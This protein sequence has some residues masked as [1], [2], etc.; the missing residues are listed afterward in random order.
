MG[1]DAL[2]I[3]PIHTDADLQQAKRRLLKLIRDNK[4]GKHDDEIEVLSTLAE[5]FENSQSRVGSPTP[6]AAI[7]FRMEEL[8][9]TARQLEPFIGS[10]ARVSEVLSGKRQLSIDMIRALHEGLGIPYESL[11]TQRLRTNGGNQVSAPTLN[12]LNTLGFNV[13]PQGVPSFITSILKNDAPLA[14]LRKTRTQRA[15]SKTDQAALQLWQAAVL[16]KGDLAR[17]SGSFDYEA[18]RSKDFRHLARMSQRADGP[19]RAIAEL[20]INGVS[21]VTL[22]G[23]P[24]TF[25]DGIALLTPEGMPVIGLTLR[26]DRIDSFW[27][28]LFH[29]VAHIAL[30]YIVLRKNEEAFVDDMEIRS[31]DVCEREADEFARNVLIPPQFLARVNWGVHTT[32]DEIITIATQARVHIAVVAGRWQREH[33]N[34]KRFSRL[35][36]RDTLRPVFLPEILTASPTCP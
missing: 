4:S 33:Q 30:H 31:E 21:V 16:K 8:E 23:L 25:L 17:A 1:I 5:T 15:S 34:Y 24:G 9:L 14:L 3:K 7:K 18:F 6:I 26:Y 19:I 10:R 20:S 12:R 22:P 2:T 35:I 28:T 36:E 27:F 11:L 13:E 32:Q 29:E